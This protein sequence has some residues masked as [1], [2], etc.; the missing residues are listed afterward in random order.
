MNRASDKG[1]CENCGR[2]FGY[3]LIHNGFN[4]RCYAY[5]EDCGATAILDCLS[6]DRAEEGLPRHAAITVKSEM[7][8]L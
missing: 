3:Y 4:E 2:E 5:C 1:R 7:F 8:L 6:Q